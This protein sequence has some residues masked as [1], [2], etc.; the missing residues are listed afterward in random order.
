MSVTDDIAKL[1]LTILRRRGPSTVRDIQ[2]ATWALTDGQIRRRL[3]Q[4]EEA[5]LVECSRGDM[6]RPPYLWRAVDR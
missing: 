1:V 6:P 4:L 2:Q 5:G 3:R